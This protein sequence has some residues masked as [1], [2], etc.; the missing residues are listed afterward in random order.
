MATVDIEIQ[1]AG[2][3]GLSIAWE[4][5]R[6]GAPVR[7]VDPRGPG[8]GASG[9]LVGALAPHTPDNWNPKK[10][11]QLEALTMHPAFWEAVTA[12]GGIDPGY[13]RCGRVQPVASGRAA[14]L[15][16]SREA[17]AATNWGDA[18]AWTLHDGASLPDWGIACPA[19]CYVHDTL[20][21]RISPAGACSALAAA[22]GNGGVAVETSPGAA[23]VRI[24]AT[25]HEGLADLS[26][27][28]GREVG[29]GVKGQ[30]ALLARDMGDAPQAY[31]D[32][33]HFVPHAGG[34]VAVGST[35]ERDWT[36]EG[37]DDALDALIARA[38]N[39]C[40]AI[41]DAPV[42]ARWAGV[43][44]RAATRSPLLGAF[45]GRAGT[46][47]ANGGFKI[48]LGIAPMVAT[49]MADLV[50]EGI[51]RIPVEFRPDNLP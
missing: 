2:I 38:R 11:F 9:G 45:P 26:R 44:P 5:L 7:L 34:T 32:G 48:G 35:S 13:A 50:L 47:I 24:L 22:L 29:N 23:G 6:R 14:V 27:T 12:A 49:I 15:A 8:A 28:L 33:L 42:V 16:R 43:R 40:P 25:G 20:S 19:S 3:F 21:A 18:G 4:C 39:L 1:G 31:A 51:D 37:A 36:T 41:A 30:A 17:D 46:F 10:A